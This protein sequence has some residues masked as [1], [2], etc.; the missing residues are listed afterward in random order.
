MRCG[1][2]LVFDPFSIGHGVAILGAD[3]ENSNVWLVRCCTF[4]HL[5]VKWSRIR[6]K[7]PEAFACHVPILS[8][9]VQDKVSV[10]G[11]APSF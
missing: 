6:S 3:K 7:V 2:G 11:V 8:G 5:G 10:I 9:G 1:D 4:L